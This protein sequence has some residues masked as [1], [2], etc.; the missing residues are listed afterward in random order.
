MSAGTLIDHHSCPTCLGHRKVF[1]GRDVQGDFVDKDC[2]TCLGLGVVARDHPFLEWRD[3]PH[4]GAS[5]RTEHLS[6]GEGDGCT[7]CGGAV[8]M[9]IDGT[10]CAVDWDDMQF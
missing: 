5:I 4:C 2:P 7:E 8:G 6:M 3:C 1:G 9:Q 10:L